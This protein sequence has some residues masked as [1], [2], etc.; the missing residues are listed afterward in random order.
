MGVVVIARENGVQVR[1]VSQLELLGAKQR[2]LE[3]L[4]MFK[5]QMKESSES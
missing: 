1:E 4:E 2:F 3:R 5:D